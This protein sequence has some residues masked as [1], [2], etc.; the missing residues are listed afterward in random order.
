MANPVWYPALDAA[1]RRKLFRFITRVLG[2]ASF[3]PSR[4]NEY[5][6]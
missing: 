3:D 1:V 6:A 4:A 2:E 5:C